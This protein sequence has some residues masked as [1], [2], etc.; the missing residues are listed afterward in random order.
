MDKLCWTGRDCKGG[1]GEGWL[2]V[3]C[4]KGYV[5]PGGGWGPASMRVEAAVCTLEQ[6]GSWAPAF[7]GELYRLRCREWCL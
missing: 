6:L 2:K 1:W 5:F 3:G 4:L 7:A